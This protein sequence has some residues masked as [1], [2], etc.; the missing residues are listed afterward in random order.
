MTFLVDTSVWALFLR[1][2]A[3]PAVPEVAALVRA[4]AR[5]FVLLS[6]DGDFQ[7]IARHS[8]L[9]LWSADA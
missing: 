5:G 7:H 2:D 3:P 4:I 1:R 8:D 6:T 9:D